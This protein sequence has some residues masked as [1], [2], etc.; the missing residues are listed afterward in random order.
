MNNSAL[1][2][3][4]VVGLM[5]A[6]CALVPLSVEDKAAQAQAV[7]CANGPCVITVVCTNGV[8]SATPDY[9]IPAGYKP[10]MTWIIQTSGY[11]FR[12][13]GISFKTAEGNSEFD[14]QNPLPGST[15][16]SRL[17]RHTKPGTYAY[18]IYLRGPGGARCDHD[19]FVFNG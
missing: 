3:S 10:A 9:Y 5:P 13:D 7:V 15:R 8:A 4:L 14:G 16:Y 18:S 17:N 2:S 1:F 12:D 19:P 6:G 11:T